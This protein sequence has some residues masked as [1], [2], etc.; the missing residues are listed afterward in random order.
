M[1]EERQWSYQQEDPLAAARGV[2][3][4]IIFGIALVGSIV[5]L[6]IG[7]TGCANVRPVINADGGGGGVAVTTEQGSWIAP[8]L[9]TGGGVYLATE[10]IDALSDKKDSIVNNG[11]YNTYNVGTGDLTVNSN[12]SETPAASAKRIK[13]EAVRRHK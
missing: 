2:V 3:H 13:S 12:N 10:I 4:G 9:L 7:L 5:L 6:V 11:T 8:V 1:N